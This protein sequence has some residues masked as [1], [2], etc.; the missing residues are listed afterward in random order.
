VA[1]RTYQRKTQR[2]RESA[3]ERGRSLWEAVLAFLTSEGVVTRG[4]VLAR[5]RHDDQT[6]V[7]GVLRDLTDSGFVFASGSGEG[8]AYRAARAEE[9]EKLRAE[10]DGAALD[11]LVWG[12]IYREG[13]ITR[14]GLLSRTGIMPEALD[15]SLARLAAQARIEAREEQGETRYASRE[16]YIPLDASAGWEAAVFDHF[17]ALVRTIVAKLSLAPGARE[18]EH[19]GGSTYSFTIYPGHPHEAEVLNILARFRSELTALRA[20]ADAHNQQHGIP[21]RSTKLTA[22]AGQYSIEHD[23]EQE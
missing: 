1:L 11:A 13:P 10:D 2:L 9:L 7:R 19:T 5:F 22:Y 3:T 23:D 21:P 12:A 16:L 15:P 14:A 17:Q 8:T 20:K 18:H 6:L 4:R